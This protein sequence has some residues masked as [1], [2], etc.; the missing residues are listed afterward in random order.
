[1]THVSHYDRPSNKLDIGPKSGLSNP[2][3]PSIP[4][5]SLL[6]ACSLVLACDGLWDTLTPEMVAEQVYTQLV[7]CSTTCAPGPS[8]TRPASAV[9]SGVQLRGENKVSTYSTSL[10]G[11]SSIVSETSFERVA[12][13]LVFCA[14]DEGSQD[15]ISCVVVMLREQRHIVR[16]YMGAKGRPPPTLA[17][18]TSR[19]QVQLGKGCEK[20]K[21][22]GDHETLVPASCCLESALSPREPANTTTTA[23]TSRVTPTRTHLAKRHSIGLPPG[24]QPLIS[25]PNGG[26]KGNSLRGSQ[27]GPS[28]KISIH[29]SEKLPNKPRSMLAMASTG[30]ASSDTHFGANASTTSTGVLYQRGRSSSQPQEEVEQVVKQLR[31]LHAGKSAHPL[32]TTGPSGTSGAGGAAT[33]GTSGSTN[34]NGNGGSLKGAGP[35][36]KAE[37][38]KNVCKGDEKCPW[39]RKLSQ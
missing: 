13:K 20:L 15:N 23:S 24:Q 39:R 28:S 18:I 31:Q 26:Q 30:T 5:I 35:A 19:V 1:M 34:A 8:A 17:E 25:P 37:K 4:S 29:L 7:N 36:S 14:R 9:S 3:S 16:D 6:L 27:A 33:A 22:S 32:G 11:T 38:G 2:S 10:A 21:K 12:E